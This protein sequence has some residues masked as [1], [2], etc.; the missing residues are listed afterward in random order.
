MLPCLAPG[1]TCMAASWAAYS[2]CRDGGR[3]RER[4]R[5]VHGGGVGEGGRDK[6]ERYG[7]ERWGGEVSVKVET[8]ERMKGG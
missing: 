1:D 8:E 3:E 6:E 4:E 7:G 5:R 2:C